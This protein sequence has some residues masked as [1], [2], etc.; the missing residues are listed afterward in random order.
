MYFLKSIVFG[1]LHTTGTTHVLEG[2]Q[3]VVIDTFT[4]Y[5]AGRDVH[6]HEA[7]RE[8]EEEGNLTAIL[9]AFGLSSPFVDYCQRSNGLSTGSR[10]RPTT[11]S[12][13]K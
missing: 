10:N 11:F 13:T 6:I 1:C 12:T 5:N 9:V 8:T 3:G 2:A 7:K 4:V